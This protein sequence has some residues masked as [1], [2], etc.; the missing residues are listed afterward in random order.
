MI[1]YYTFARANVHFWQFIVLKKIYF[2]FLINFIAFIFATAIK[3]NM[4][5][6]KYQK[7][8]MMLLLIKEDF[9][10]K[11]PINSSFIILS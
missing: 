9:F 1:L 2:D 3:F 4:E 10:T 6:S 7:I 11:I 8:Q 5:I